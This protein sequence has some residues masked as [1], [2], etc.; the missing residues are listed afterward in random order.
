ME[1]GEVWGLSQIKCGFG[2]WEQ[3]KKKKSLV[4]AQGGVIKQ[5]WKDS[6]FCAPE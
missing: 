4:E 1:I 6:L 3:K 5:K 2:T